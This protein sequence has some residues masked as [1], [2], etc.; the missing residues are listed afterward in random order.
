MAEFLTSLS[1]FMYGVSLF[2]LS[3]TFLYNFLGK[4]SGEWSVKGILQYYWKRYGS[5]PQESICYDEKSIEAT[6]FI[7]SGEYYPFQPYPKGTKIWILNERPHREDGPA[8]EWPGGLYSWWLHG[9]NYSF[10][11]FIKKSRVS[12]EIKCQLILQYG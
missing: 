2:I 7:H 12:N 3:L 1:L 9:I 6:W 8:I 5:T 10:D 11:D 4:K